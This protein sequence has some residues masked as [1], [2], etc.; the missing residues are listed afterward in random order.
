MMPVRTLLLIVVGILSSA[1]CLRA[2]PTVA[3]SAP[4]APVVC[5][6]LIYHSVREYR[7]SD[8]VAARTYIITPEALEKELQFLS[9]AGMTTIRFDQLADAVENGT[10]LPADPVIISFDDGWET[11]YQTALPLLEKYHFHATFFI[12]TNGIGAK[13]FMTADQLRELADAG[14]E[15]GC[16]SRSHP[17]LARITDAATLRR[18]ILDS[19]IK[20][21]E[22]LGRPVTAFAYPFG[23]YTKQIVE[24]VRDAGYRS[25]R[26]TYRGIVH[27]KADL[28]TL[29]GLIDITN[30]TRIEEGL[31]AADLAEKPEYPPA[32]I[33]VSEYLP[34]GPVNQ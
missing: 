33:D 10:P 7:D 14:M 20:L 24:A 29:T 12:F 25:A 28:F 2:D 17:Y 23:H 16:H 5:P 13:H 22:I 30:V 1:L 19:R 3:L 11:Q 34:S 18:E 26:S 31:R 8:S 32:G 4:P 27:G 6:I 15:I 21:E 9:N